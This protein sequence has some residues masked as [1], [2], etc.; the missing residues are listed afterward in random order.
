MMLQ[1][2]S[3]SFNKFHM[4]GSLMYDSIYHICI[5]VIDIVTILLVP[6]K[7]VM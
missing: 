6:A 1:L 5:V 7:S 2:F 4:K 3:G